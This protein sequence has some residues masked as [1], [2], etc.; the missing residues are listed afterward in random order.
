MNKTQTYTIYIP[1]EDIS[2]DD[3]VVAR[4][5]SGLDAIKMAL[6]HS[7][8]WSAHLCEDESSRS[9]STDG[10]PMPRSGHTTSVDSTR[11]APPSSKQATARATRQAACR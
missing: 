9:G 11:S 6:E 5:L 2:K 1:F 7:G 3:V 4:N 10:L 8:S